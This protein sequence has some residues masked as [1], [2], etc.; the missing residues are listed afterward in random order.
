MGWYLEVLVN[1][2]NFGGRATRSEYWWFSLFNLIIVIALAIVVPAARAELVLL[3]Y[4]A[5]IIVPSLAVSV[6][7][8][9]DTDRSGWWLLLGLI[10]FGGIILLIFYL[11]D[12]TPGT[13]RYGPD[14]KTHLAGSGQSAAMRSSRLEGEVMRLYQLYKTG[15]ISLDEYQARRQALFSRR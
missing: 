8:L 6:R 14:P 4:T 9:H 5:G 11:L 15:A 13:N 12:G 10:P 3:I 7:R 1:Y 2:A